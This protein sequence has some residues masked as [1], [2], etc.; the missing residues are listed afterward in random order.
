M[1]KELGVRLLRSLCFSIVFGLVMTSV[2]GPIVTED[3][4]DLIYYPE[5]I[6]FI[7]GVLFFFGIVLV[8]LP[9]AWKGPLVVRSIAFTALFGYLYFVAARQ[10]V[11]PLH[12]VN[13]LL[14]ML[15]LLFIGLLLT[16]WHWEKQ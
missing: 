5:Y 10:D 9:G 4:G 14:M 7:A 13:L 8:P 1:K 2:A 16:S 11:P 12:P 15:P 3:Y 6:G